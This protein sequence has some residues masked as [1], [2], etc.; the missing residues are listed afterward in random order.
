M[1]FIGPSPSWRHKFV[2]CSILFTAVAV[3][4][5][6]CGSGSSKT[7]PP[8]ALAITTS[9]LANGTV[10]TAYSAR[11]A[12]TGGTS[13]YTWAVTK[14]TLPAGL[15]LA[16]STGSIVGTPSAAANAAALTFTVT[17][18][19]SPAQKASAGLSLSIAAPAVT[20]NVSPA[21]AEIVVTQALSISAKT[22]DGTAIAWSASGSGCAGATCGTLSGTSDAA[23]TYTAPPAAGTYTFTAT[24]VE[25]PTK[26][27]S[28]AIT[29]TDLAGVTTWHNDQARDGA[30]TQ[31]YALTPA[32][33]SS[34]KFGKLFSCPVDGA[35]YAQP[36]WMPQLSI[37]SAKYNVVFVATQHDSLYAFAA[38]AAS[39][40]TC[41]QLWHVNLIDGPHGGSA[42][43]TSV[44]S[45]G[46]NTM[47]GSGF[48]DIAPE[49]GVT[50][51]PVI[52]P[53]T[54]T[55][56]V[57]SKSVIP[58]SMTFFQRLH[59]IDLLTGK[60]KFAGPKTIAGTYPG[61]GDGGKTTTFVPRQQNQRAGLA[62]A[63]GIVYI[64][65][66]S[67]E[68]NYPYYGWVMGYNAQTLAQLSAFNDTPDFLWGGIWMGGAA[69]SID[70]TGN[71]FLI[72]GNGTFNADS[73][74]SP[75]HDYG[76]SLLK[77]TPAL[78]V[79][80]YFTPSDQA[81]D[82]QN[83]ADFGSGGTA[84]LVDL[85]K[86]GSN[87][88]HLVIGGGKD[89]SLYL[90]NGDQLGGSGDS[91][92]WQQFNMGTSVFSTGAFWNS[93]YYIAGVGGPLTAFSLNASTAKMNPTASS[94]SSNGFGFPGSTPAISAS[95]NSN[96]IL[97][98]MD[99][100]LY[101][102]PQSQGCAAAVLHAY[103]ASNVAKELWNS[104]QTS[105]D[106]AGFAVKFTVPTIA[107]G[108]VYVGT[109]GNN[110]GSDDT[111]TSTP[112]ELDVYGLQ[113]N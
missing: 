62:L 25:D 75:N 1:A 61:S 60:E 87:P 94:A 65:W 6:G 108:R 64:A 4:I 77:L 79:A 104:S 16:A 76:D 47:V 58:S 84:I 69:P 72:T 51:T 67:H 8:P 101:C 109:R 31:E 63:N 53:S 46:T 81:S 71:L 20:V 26:S 36:L 15:T 18:S 83:D 110:A 99:N 78:A 50:G 43:E 39:G 35:I 85:P 27:A 113:P 52:D 41:K 28:L 90:L 82:Q 93:T 59:A 48:G 45:A 5:A 100:G 80:Q 66:S 86:N 33:V 103:D 11:L 17:D 9:T 54:N 7:P 70:S 98:A 89:G 91:H 74:T 107:N 21:R 40:G 3:T 24:S 34:A 68:D 29:V 111:S 102:T 19:G 22:S 44:I 56:Y 97:W 10:G 112:G 42:G 96:G 23:L 37:G 88:T 2:A 14:G 57:V 49:V 32:T 73:P 105:K 38:E 13:P 55:L 12:A 92:A 95:G 30:N 106:S